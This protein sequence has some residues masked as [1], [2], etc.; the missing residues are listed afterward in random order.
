M[1][2]VIK[3]SSKNQTKDAIKI[4]LF[5]WLIDGE[6]LEIEGEEALH[7]INRIIDL[8]DFGYSYHDVFDRAL[9][10]GLTIP[11][12]IDELI[13]ESTGGEDFDYV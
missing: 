1:K 4:A 10:Y 12:A 6:G 8:Q 3:A 11:E 7:L 2:K 5:N 9:E 13:Q